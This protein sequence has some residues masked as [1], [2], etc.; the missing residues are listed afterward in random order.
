MGFSTEAVTQRLLTRVAINRRRATAEDQLLYSPI[1]IS[2]GRWVPNEAGSDDDRNYAMTTLESTVFVTEHAS[3]LQDYLKQVDHVG[4][5]ASRGLGWVTTEV[6]M[7]ADDDDLT[8]LCERR[9]NMNNE[10]KRRWD[11][12]K[13]WPGCS[14]PPCSPDTGCYFTIDLYSDA[15]LKEHGLLPTMILKPEMLKERCG[16]QDDSLQL[17]RAYSGY[18]YRGGWNTAWG[19]P[20]DVEVAV[21][22]GSVF[23]FWTQEPELWEEALLDL[24]QWGIGDRTSEGFGQVRVCDEFHQQGD[25]V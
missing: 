21:P 3:T 5:G 9:N 25:F 14:T 1:V 22:I 11:K 2:E 18:D 24:E 13:K 17:L 6:E 15:V 7:L 4:S 20:K 19:L 12:L 8:S 10:I 23:V 16:I